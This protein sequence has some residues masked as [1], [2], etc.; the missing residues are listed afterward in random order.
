MVGGEKS[1]L[2]HGTNISAGIAIL[3]SKEINV[4]ILAV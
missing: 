3:F 2:S 4:N 1:V